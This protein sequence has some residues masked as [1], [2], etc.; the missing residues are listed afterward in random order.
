MQK[1]RIAMAGYA[2]AAAATLLDSPADRPDCCGFVAGRRAHRV[3]A[4]DGR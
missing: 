2:R 4:A 1:V 3:E